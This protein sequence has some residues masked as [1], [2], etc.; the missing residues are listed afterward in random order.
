MVFLLLRPREFNCQLYRE[1]IFCP[2]FKKEET[3]FLY[4]PQ[5]S[6][7]RQS[8]LAMLEETL[9]FWLEYQPISGCTQLRFF[10]IC[11]IVRYFLHLAIQRVWTPLAE[12]AA[13]GCALVGYTG[14][15]GKEIF[16]Y[17]NSMML[18]FR[19]SMVIG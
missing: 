9:V 11:R 8:F 5:E 17:L 15:G 18:P 3:S 1:P 4:A 14:L 13:C 7:R 10:S 19:L 2:S 16:L 12:A 6:L